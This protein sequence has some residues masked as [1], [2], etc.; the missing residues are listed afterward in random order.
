MDNKVADIDEI[1]FRQYYE[2]FGCGELYTLHHNFGRMVTLSCI[3]FI[4]KELKLKEVQ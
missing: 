1:Y 4:I 3:C 2:C